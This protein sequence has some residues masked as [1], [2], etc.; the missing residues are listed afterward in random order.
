MNG[1]L[2]AIWLAALLGVGLGL[3]PSTRPVLLGPLQIFAGI[4][5]LGVVLVWLVPHAL[6]AAGLSGPLWVAAGLTV[7]PGAGLVRRWL[8]R[9]GGNRS[10]GSSPAPQTPTVSPALHASYLGVAIHSFGDGIALAAEGHGGPLRWALIAHQVPVIALVTAAFLR[11]SNLSAVARGTGLAVASTA[12]L[13]AT[14]QLPA[15]LTQSAHGLLDAL[16]AGILLHLVVDQWQAARTSMG[17]VRA[18]RLGAAAALLGL[19]VVALPWLAQ[20]E[21]TSRLPCH[22]FQTSAD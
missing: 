17:T 4:A 12:G 10:R 9:A 20:P 15:G 22:W 1:A 6:G 13:W 19:G 3:S 2:V 7:V 5:S 14:G 21:E 16:V 8:S 18:R 11:F